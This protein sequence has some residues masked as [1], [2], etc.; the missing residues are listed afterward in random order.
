MGYR[1]TQQ[2]NILKKKLYDATKKKYGKGVYY[3]DEKC[4]LIKVSL[5]DCS[6]KP[7]YFKRQYNK[8]V[9]RMNGKFNRG[10]YKKIY[11]YSWKII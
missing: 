3:D 7:K 2:E 11:D 10:L 1:R 6:K 9:R 5:S 4:R 8:A